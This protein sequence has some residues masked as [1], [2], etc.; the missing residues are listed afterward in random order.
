MILIQ[1]TVNE[2]KP[3]YL[4]CSTVI[5]NKSFT[6]VF[7]LIYFDEILN[8]YTKNRMNIIKL[9]IMK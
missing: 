3:V 2:N 8:M 7:R 9:F 1:I 6:L 5:Y 4:L